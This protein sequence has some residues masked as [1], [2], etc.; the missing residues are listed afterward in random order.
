[1]DHIEID[2]VE[3]QLPQT[4][5]EGAVER[6]RRKLIMPDLRS[7]EELVP[8]HAG[9]RDGRADGGF[10]VVYRGGVD[11]SVAERDRTLDD[12]LGVGSRHPEGAE[13][14]ARHRNTLCRDRL[15]DVFLSRISCRRVG[16]VTLLRCRQAASHHNGGGVRRML[17]PGSAPLKAEVRLAASSISARATSQPRVLHSAALTAS[18]R[19]ARTGSLS[20]RRARASAPPTLPVIPVIAY[21]MVLQKVDVDRSGSGEPGI[22]AALELAVDRDDPLVEETQDL[23]EER[24]GDVL[25][26]VEPEVA[27]EQACPGD[28]AGGPPVRSRLHVD[29]EGQA[30]FMRLSRELVEAAGIERLRRAHLLDI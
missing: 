21:M 28:A 6:I 15:H 24:T 27:V 5:V 12:R 29:V 7:D 16:A 22:E 9:R 20:A 30:P 25:H 13:A 4:G 14:E 19:T 26:R 10:V 23:S 2:M 17:W 18:R 3:P 1:M 11:M 8:V